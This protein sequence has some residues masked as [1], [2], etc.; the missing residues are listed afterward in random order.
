MQ[1]VFPLG[2]FRAW[3]KARFHSSCLV[4]PRPSQ[5]TEILDNT[6]LQEK[7]E[8][9]RQIRK[10]GTGDFESLREYTPGESFKRIYWKAYAREQGLVS[11][12][13]SRENGNSVWL[14]FHAISSP[15][16]EKKLSLLA[17]MILDL[18]R[19]G[20]RFGLRLPHKNIALDTG[21]GHMHRCLA[22]LALFS[23]SDTGN[24]QA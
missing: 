24:K 20:R 23:C 17:R 18:S 21:K 16:P 13:F 6:D 7:D 3:S 5:Q 8:E 4:Y 9:Q 11:K 12:N 14:D 19:E 1:T 15:D 10:Q 2:L 22:E